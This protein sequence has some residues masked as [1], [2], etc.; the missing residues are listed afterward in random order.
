MFGH[1]ASGGGSR[2]RRHVTNDLVKPN[3]VI[4]SHANEVA[5]KDG[6]VIAG[7]K[8]ETFIKATKVPVHVPL[9]GHT[10]TFDN[11]GN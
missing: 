7:T 1:D 3:S 10:L 5:T 11:S 4:P 2:D 8:T 9:S 6:K